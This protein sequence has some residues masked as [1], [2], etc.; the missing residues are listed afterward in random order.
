MPGSGNA[1][2]QGLILRK[3]RI[4]MLKNFT[5]NRLLV[6]VVTAGFAALLVDSIVEHRDILTKELPSLIPIAF[7][8]AGLALGAIAFIG[9]KQKWIRVLH[10]FLFA[11]FLVACGGVY[12]H[13][14]DDDDEKAAATVERQDGEKKEKDKP[15]L[16]PLSFAGL[17]AVGL[18]GTAR[19][20]PAEVV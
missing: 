7:S 19:K 20:W 18:L 9:W 12:F 15:L 10:V 4:G 17:A 13:L 14:G 2:R 11:A 5:L 1:A 8:A 16:A 3:G 6:L